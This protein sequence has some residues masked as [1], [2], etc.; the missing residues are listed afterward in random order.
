MPCIANDPRSSSPQPGKIKAC[1]HPVLHCYRAELS[2]QL[3]L[4]GR[5]DNSVAAL[6]RGSV[7]FLV[8]PWGSPN[9]PL[10]VAV[11]SP[12]C[13]CSGV[14]SEVDC[15]TCCREEECQNTDLLGLQFGDACL[16]SVCCL[17]SRDGTLLHLEGSSGSRQGPPKKLC[18]TG[19]NTDLSRIGPCLLKPAPTLQTAPSSCAWLG[20]LHLCSGRSAHLQLG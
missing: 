9:S 13:L 1:F 15:D 18:S 14:G 20:L 17:F 12:P 11:L 2:E 6:G 8:P 7:V 19:E 4:V 5:G 3:G 10:G 16:A